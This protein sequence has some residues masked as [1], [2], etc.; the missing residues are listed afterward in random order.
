MPQPACFLLLLTALTVAPLVPALAQHAPVMSGARPGSLR[1]DIP[2]TFPGG[3]GEMKKFLLTALQYP[4]A[5]ADHQVSGKVVVAF[6][7]QTNGSCTGFNVVSPPLGYGCEAEAL[8]VAAL[9]PRWEPARQRTT[10]VP[11]MATLTLPFG[12]SPTVEK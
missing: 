12:A 2:P 4:A 11:V 10:P 6:T 7:V 9:M 1:P 3:A 8:R 5:A